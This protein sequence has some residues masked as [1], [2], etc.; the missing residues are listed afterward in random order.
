MFQ[1]LLSSW[2]AG[3]RSRSFLALLFLGAAVVT[4][5]YLS[6]S[7]SPR[8]PQTVALDVGLSG[9][10]FCLVLFAVTLVQELLTR[11]IDRRGVVLTLSY[12][13][14]RHSYIFGRFFGVA[15]LTAVGALVLGML[16]WIAVLASGSHYEQQ[17]PVALGL[18]YWSCIAGVWLD[19][20]VVTSFTVWIA[21]LSTVPM[22]P[23]A[24]GFL[25]AIGGRALGPVADFVQ[26]GAGGDQRIA[27]D[28]API[29]SV[30][31]W[32][33]PDLSRLDFRTWALY[34]QTPEFGLLWQGSVMAI[35]YSVLMIGLAVLCFSRREFS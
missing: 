24:T 22:M 19:V 15:A 1:F 23:L 10:R 7:F 6:A 20:A 8:Q 21:T 12:P 18:P 30:I 16:L 13:V 17:F 2:R 29:L 4:M 9:L 14:P 35:T 5:A 31:R 28:Y 27:A 32:V 11:E 33:L 3:F 34:G 25:F 26:Q